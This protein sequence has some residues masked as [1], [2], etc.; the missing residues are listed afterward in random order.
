MS[1]PTI[2]DIRA[3]AARRRTKRQRFRRLLIG[4]GIGVVLLAGLSWGVLPGVIRSQI[5]QRGSE[6]TGRAVTVEK[7][8]L[9]PLSLSV[10]I[11]GLDVRDLDGGDLLAW[12][13]LRV[14]AN[15]WKTLTGSWGADEISLAGLR[16]RLVMER[17]GQLNIA[18][19]LAKLETEEDGDPRPLE[20]GYLEVTDAQVDL[21]DESRSRP[22]ATTIGP[23][24][25]SLSDFHTEIDAEAPYEF[26]AR[27]DSGAQL[28]WR[29][30]LSLVPLRSAGDFEL[31]GIS[32]PKYEAYFAELLPF[33]IDGGL[34]GASGSYT[35]EWVEDIPNA[36]LTDGTVSVAGVILS[37]R[38]Q[39]FGRQ[40]V[41]TVEVT[42]VNADLAA[43]RFTATELA[44]ADATVE[45]LRSP[46]G[47]E[48]IGIS[49][50][51]PD[52]EDPTAVEQMA[53]LQ[54]VRFDRIRIDRVRYQLRDETLLEPAMIGAQLENLTLDQVVVTDLTQPISVAAALRFP[55]GGSATVKGTMQASPLKPDLTVEVSGLALAPVAAHVKHL[56]SLELVDGTLEVT[57]QVDAAETGI[58]FAGS[59]AVADL[60]LLDAAGEVLAGFR[61]LNLAGVDVRVAEPALSIAQ[62]VLAGAQGH[63]VVAADGSIN[64]L[65][66]AAH[67]A[68]DDGAAV[69]VEGSAPNV[70]IG[71]IEVRG[72][73]M[74]V[75][76]QS[77]SP[78]MEVS[79]DE[80]D[81]VMQGW[82]SQ[83][84]ARAQI[85]LTGKVNGVAPV[86]VAGDL[87][88]LGQPAHADL[89]IDVDRVDLLPT[90]GYVG[91]YA[92]FELEQGRMSLDI[93]FQLRDRAIES[94]TVTVLEDFT[95]GAKTDSPDAVKLP[96]KLGVAL[97]KDSQGEMVIDVP[98]AGHLDDPEFRIS[99]VVWRVIT[100]VLTKAAT[101][102]FALLGGVVGGSGEVDLAHH[103]FDSGEATIPPQTLE[104]LAALMVALD[105]R[106]EV[107]IG[108]RGEYDP[109]T[110]PD[111]L[112]PQV[113]ESMLRERADSADWTTDGGWVGPAREAGLV[114]LYEEVFGEPP[115]DPTG[116][117]PPPEI[118]AP[119]VGSEP[120]TVDVSEGA[121][122]NRTLLALI[123]RIFTGRSNSTDPAARPVQS[124]SP[125]NS[126]PL[127]EGIQE[128]LAVL[129]MSEIEARLIEQI[130]VPESALRALGRQRA[131]TTRDH[132]IAAGLAA[133]RMTM[134]EVVAGEARVTLDLR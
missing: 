117:I 19:I 10:E 33:E 100:N 120:V 82:S 65:D 114:A 103:V 66:M 39:D 60:R 132:L 87:N 56:T 44:M 99:R 74:T 62:V 127:P 90:G 126:F 101:S 8:A 85:T 58:G 2:K 97:L 110:D 106:P 51:A 45:L 108:I 84:V 12:E 40:T 119:E 63:V 41:S 118:P 77:V 91:K 133:E 23:V 52:M 7:V 22:F 130:S 121:D 81:S 35:F 83:D 48:W 104:S 68:G 32:I 11:T 94:D 93:D 72:S 64:I 96:V 55:A 88:P 27:T 15:L 89:K 49:L 92:G 115:V 30:A 131:Q 67:M 38:E 59:V 36:T 34:A 122:D 9:N 123:R 46:A 4:T 129:P 61:E 86:E 57:G 26:V 76:D 14:N 124:E 80:V 17:S 95:L 102:P 43:G 53:R 109:G 50:A 113:M 47:I 13:R 69:A 73:R 71:R 105:A 5:E 18:D 24:T 37:P 6:F 134:V 116:E 31:E 98:V 79:I 112:R 25:F 125:P 1:T 78:A 42:G 75:R 111:A 20:V 70:E 28:S 3:A 107:S 16:G 128:E 21:S 29:G 54:D